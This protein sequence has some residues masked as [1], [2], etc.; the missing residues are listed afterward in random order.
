M[1]RKPVSINKKK[2]AIVLHDMRITQHETFHRLKISR[3]CIRQTIRKS[4]QFHRFNAK[5]GSGR[6]RKMTKHQERLIRLQQLRDDTC[7]L[8]ESV[9]YAHTDLNLSISC[10]TV[11]RI[12]RNHNISSYIPP[13]KPRITSVQSHNC[14]QWCHEHLNWSVE[15]CCQFIFSDETNYEVLN[16][17]NR[18]YL[19]RFC[20]DQ[21]RFERSQQR[22]HRDSGIR[23]ELP[24]HTCI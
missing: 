18:I 10:S 13:R 22:V 7:S 8:A 20:N 6:T 19:H 2:R 5:P 23:F 14:L 11:S 21:T 24:A 12:L 4:D 16:R 3:H 1:G 15:D 9:R 17:K